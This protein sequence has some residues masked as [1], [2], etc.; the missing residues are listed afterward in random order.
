MAIVEYLDRGARRNPDGPCLTAADGRSMTYREVQRLS[1]RIGNKLIDLGFR[2][3][4]VGSVLSFND[5][6]AFACTF[7][8]ARAG[9]TWLP[10][11]PRNKEDDSHYLFDFMDCRVLLFSSDFA[12]LVAALRPRLPGIKA[13]VCLDRDLNDV[14][15][16]QT[17]LEAIDDRDPD[18]PRSAED[19]AVLFPTGGTTG[20]SK[21]VQWSHRVVHNVVATYMTCICYDQIERPVNMAA[22]PLTH[23]AGLICW[24]TLARGGQVVILPKPDIEL[25]LDTIERY[26]VTELFL[27]PTVIYRMLEHPG[28]E[29]RD[30]SSLR[31]F[32][33]AAAPMSVDKL[34]RALKVFGPCMTQTYGQAEAPML[35]TFFSPAEHMPDGQ[36][37]ADER[38]ASCGYPTPLVEVRILDEQNNELPHG[39]PGE[40]CVRGDL[41]MDGYYKQ[42]EKTAE[43]VIGGW[44]HTGDV[45]IQGADGWLRIVDRK[46]DM[47][48]T[49][50]LNVYPQEIEQVIWSH[51]A[52]GDCAVI[53]LPDEDWG[54]R[55]TAVVELAPE[56]K[57]DAEDIMALCKQQL[58]SVKAPKTVYF[59][60]LPR[61]PNG[62]VLKRELRDEYWQARDR[63]V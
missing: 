6:F 19:R 51:P 28:V 45:G 61:S 48:I 4:D 26:R 34:K 55:V 7:G 31:Y 50:G 58:G 52:V 8:L 39:E 49:G 44:L 35:A 43:T 29:D 16:M 53:G 40:I 10:A 20:R 21:G 18:L 25:M 13:W 27:P 1:Y 62:K 23:A 33:Y 46:K 54:E 41:V 32:V 14:P 47:I 5:A 36:M 56:G 30:Y 59:R 2:R 38:L 12:A 22:A 9:M 11:N 24:P 63:K 17:W 37:A 60:E 3:G 15:S 42:P 57:A